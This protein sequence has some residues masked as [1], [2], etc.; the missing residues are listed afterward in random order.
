MLK[1]IAC[2]TTTTC[3]V[4]TS[5]TIYRGDLSTAGGAVS[6]SWVAS[7][8]DPSDPLNGIA[9][10]SPSS[11][12]A[13]GFAGQVLT[14]IDPT[15]IHWRAQKIGTGPVAERP[16]L[17]AVSCP[18]DGVCVAVGERGF[19]ATTTNNWADWSLDQ[20]GGSPKPNLGAIDC[21][22]TTRCIVAGDTVLAGRR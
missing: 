19:I 15:F 7:D 4:A 2:P 18:A 5:E 10:S 3:V 22:S 20:V 13:V 17:K 11:C 9:C 6:W 14:T 1:A 12:T 21:K 16:P 8:A